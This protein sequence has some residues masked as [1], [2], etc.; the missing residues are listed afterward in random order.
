MN[1]DILYKHDIPQEAEHSYRLKKR[2][3]FSFKPIVQM[4]LNK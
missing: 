3:I 2:E 1:D 4:K